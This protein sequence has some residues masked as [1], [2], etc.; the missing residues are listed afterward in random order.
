MLSPS[1]HHCISFFLSLQLP[2]SGLLQARLSTAAVGT[3][4]AGSTIN[5]FQY[6]ILIADSGS[7]KTTWCTAGSKDHAGR[8]CT[9]AGINPFL[10]TPDEI[11]VTLENEFTLGR[12]P[13]SDIY[14]YGAGCANPKKNE[15]VRQPLSRFF[16]T[17]EIHVDSDLMGAARSLCGN[18]PG[19]AAI[20]GT[21]SNSCYY[22]GIRI[23]RHVS[24]LGYILGDEGSGTVLGRKLLA[25]ILK[26]Q[27][28]ES[29]CEAFFKE[30][31]LEPADILEH[32]YRKPFP[33]RFMAQF[34]HF[35]AAHKEN[36]AVY[37]LIKESF[38][39]FFNRNIR[40]YPEAAR[41]PVNVTG[42]I[43]WHFRDILTETA[44]EAGFSTGAV[45]QSPMEGLLRYHN[46]FNL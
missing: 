24:P 1:G 35:L 4:E 26:N 39:G 46:E 34:T 3:R 27:L 17:D 19:I 22:D 10:Q 33:N 8:S 20:L 6:M 9:T 37:R 29:V 23:A 15:E 40:Q 12:G 14:F 18:S 43:G 44:S 2:A 11:Y 45:T 36:P 42:S 32:V 28:P 7:T 31:K 41:L 21:G 16:K 13:F 38:T 30:Y 25:D 5:T